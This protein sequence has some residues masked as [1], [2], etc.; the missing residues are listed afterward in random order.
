MKIYCYIHQDNAQ[1][2]YLDYIEDDDT[3]F[4]ASLS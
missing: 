1:D 3:S 2:D 4:Y